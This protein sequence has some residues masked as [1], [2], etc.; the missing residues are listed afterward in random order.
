VTLRH[1]G[2]GA[3]RETRCS[4]T[5]T[6]CFR[7]EYKTDRTKPLPLPSPPIPSL[8]SPLTFISPEERSRLRRLGA[9]LLGYVQGDL[10]RYPRKEAKAQLGGFEKNEPR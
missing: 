3:R 6:R 10:A 7:L 9:P 5:K 1:N 4:R 2:G 8:R